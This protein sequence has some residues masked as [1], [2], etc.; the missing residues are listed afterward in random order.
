MT[1]CANEDD[2]I[3]SELVKR[4]SVAPKVAFAVV[5]EVSDKRMIAVDWR[6]RT[7]LRESVDGLR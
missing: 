5:F 4:Q 1:A 6:H 2:G 3:G 7:G